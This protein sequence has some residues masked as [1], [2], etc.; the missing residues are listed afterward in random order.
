MTPRKLSPE[1]AVALGIQ[2]MRELDMKEIDP[3]LAFAALG[4]AFFETHLKLGMGPEDW[5]EVSKEV[6]DYLKS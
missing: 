1:K 6:A 2:I 5:L 3:V 4:Y